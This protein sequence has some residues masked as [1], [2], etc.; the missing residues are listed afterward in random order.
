M[1]LYELLGI[2]RLASQEEI[3]RAYFR[4]VRKHTPEHDPEMFMRIRNAYEKLSDVAKR[5][6]YD[7][8]LA[9]FQNVPED[10]IADI[11]ESERLIAKDLH[12]DAI[13]LLESKKYSDPEAFAAV[14]IALC[15]AYIN[16][17]K[18]GKAVKIVE[19]LR[20]DN[21]KDLRFLHLALKV[22]TLRGWA[23]KANACRE[24]LDRLDPGNEENILALIDDDS[25]TPSFLGEIVENIEFYGKKAPLICVTILSRCFDLL[26][27]DYS[28][29]SFKQMS[30]A[31]NL[32]V[33]KKQSWDDLSFAAE[34]L[35]EHTVDIPENK[36]SYVILVLTKKIMPAIYSFDRYDIIPHIYQ[37]IKN[38]HMEEVL[39]HPKYKT[40]LTGYRAIE[41]VKA[42][43]PKTLA[44]LP[45]MHVFSAADFLSKKDLVDYRNEVL[46]LEFDV[47]LGYSRYKPYLQR[48]K[49]EFEDL[50]SYCADFWE[51]IQRYNEAQRL[52]DLE[53]RMSKLKGVVDRFTLSWLGEDDDLGQIH[54]NTPIRVQKIGRN[55]PCPCGSGKKYKKC[56]G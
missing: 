5:K 56:C 14:Q 8:I 36:G 53:R 25:Q 22:Y 6:N 33:S 28:L 54:S 7:D 32:G 41:A 19:K 50:Y 21:P 3:K 46:C 29:H 12:L 55:E 30:L 15:N 48:F 1:N 9:R 18:I 39:Q 49:N 44:A 23:Q 37:T 4:M 43:I 52:N 34:K 45:V 2:E 42:G 20:K 10:A 40:L 13:R 35:A 27:D 31:D 38:L 51:T 47:L 16:S 11:I 26:D 17:D 24:A